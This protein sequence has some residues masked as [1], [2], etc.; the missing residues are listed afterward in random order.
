MSVAINFIPKLSAYYSL[1]KAPH[2]K[3]YSSYEKSIKIRNHEYADFEDFTPAEKAM[4]T[5][6]IN[7]LP[8]VIL[9]SLFVIDNISFIKIVAGKDWDFPYTYISD[10]DNVIALTSLAIHNFG[11]VGFNNR[12]IQE[13]LLHEIIH[14]HQKRN[15]ED[16]DIYYKKYYNFEKV[17]CSNYSSIS[18]KVITNPDGYVSH[19]MIWVISINNTYW[20]PY[21]DISMQE[22]MVNV[23]YE[24]N[25]YLVTDNYAPIDIVKIYNKM[26]KVESQRYHPN[27]IFARINAKKLIFGLP[28]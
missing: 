22:K 17:F 14:L 9:S 21:L 18:E 25:K 19:G 16:Y 8:H 28:T 2:L 3:W 15:Q 20:M 12:Y 23:I 7:G 26:F 24:N 10:K 5:F 6:Y 4:L 1:M 27:E 13:T 11:K